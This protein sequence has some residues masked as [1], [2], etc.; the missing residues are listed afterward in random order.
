MYQQGGTIENAV[1][2]IERREYVLPAIQR[3]FVWDQEQICAL[4]DSLMQGYPYGEFLFWRIEPERSHKYRYYDFVRDYHQRDNPHCPEL[5]IL[6]NQPLTAVLDGQQRLTAFNIGLRGSMAVKLPRRWWNS[7]DAFPIRVLALDLLASD[8]RDEDGNC[9][10]FAFVERSAIG[11]G[12]GQLWFQVSDILAMSPTRGRTSSEPP[13]PDPSEWLADHG[14]VGDQ[15]KHANRILRRLVWAI[16]DAPTVAY[17]EEKNQDIEHVLSI[18]I[19]RN[20]GGTVLDYSDLLLSIAVSQWE[21]KDARKE[22]HD[23]VDELNRIGTDLRLSKDFVLKAG[24]MLTGIASVGFKVSNFTHANMAI[25]QHRWADIKAALIATVQLAASFGFDSK[26]IRA[27]SAL[28]PIAYYLY[29]NGSPVGFSSKNRYQRDRDAIRHWLT[30]SILK[31]SGIWGSGLDTLLTALR[32]VLRESSG[33]RFPAKELGK[34]MAQRGKS[35]DFTEE[36][37]DDLA[38]M[39]IVDR[40]VFAL[41]TLLYPFVN[42]GTQHFHVDHVFPKSRFTERRLREAGVLEDEIEAFLSRVDRIA[43]L[44][45]LDGV[46]NNE[47]SAKLP[48]AWLRE[49]YEDERDRRH[50]LDRHLLGDMPDDI[51]D[52]LSFYEM[53]RKRLRERIVDLVQQA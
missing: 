33:E 52:F 27:T 4:F 41:L 7:P 35:L 42:V 50:Y 23:L 46:V 14:I 40:R 29:K 32:D 47:K 12:D 16:C 20:S 48:A 44:Q 36:E 17:Y 15:F 30:R 39:K 38:D 18:F 19:R 5:A 13:G 9:Y 3:E 22:V 49:R 25:L 6:R 1:K 45:F 8:E 37:I 28:L 31:A 10:R 24:L 11:L 21:G 34:Q 53:R 2:S 26:S 43:N 51:T